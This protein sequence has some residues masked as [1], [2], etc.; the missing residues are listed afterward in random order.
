M[1]DDLKARLL[2]LVEDLE[3]V[4]EYAEQAAHV[5]AALAR[6]EELERSNAS[7]AEMI[8][9]VAKERDAAVD[10]LDGVKV[11]AKHMISHSLSDDREAFYDGSDAA[12]MSILDLLKDRKGE[13]VY[14][15][16]WNEALEAARL[17]AN[18]YANE[19]WGNSAEQ[20]AAENIE[21]QI[22]ALKRP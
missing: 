18:E 10:A 16:G 21:A 7:Y 4:S 8:E 22:A 19:A 14:Q 3:H 20:A 6:I 9:C 2:D 15:R 11:Y 13:D 12:Y 17:I 5:R 1:S